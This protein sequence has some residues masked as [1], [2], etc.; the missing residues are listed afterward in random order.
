MGGS[1]ALS[2]LSGR[3]WD[4]AG[5]CSCCGWEKGCDQGW[6]A[7]PGGKVH[8]GSCSLGAAFPQRPRFIIFRLHCFRRGFKANYLTAHKIKLVGESRCNYT[9]R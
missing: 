2:L 3:F 1:E 8:D 5:C 9:V 7:G 6:A 4:A